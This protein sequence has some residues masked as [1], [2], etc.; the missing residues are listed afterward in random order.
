MNS[1]EP[2]GFVDIAREQRMALRSIARKIEA[3]EPLSA[4]DRHMAVAAIEAAVDRIPEAPPRG[5][6]HTLKVD[7]GR[8]AWEYALLRKAEGNSH[9]AATQVLADR[10]GMTQQAADKAIR[11]FGIDKALALLP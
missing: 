6:G 2:E 5:R 4:M 9:T 10:H 11:A 3:G 7:R 8:L 1:D